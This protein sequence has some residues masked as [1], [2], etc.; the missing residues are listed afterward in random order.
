MDCLFSDIRVGKQGWG[1]GEASERL[2]LF[3]GVLSDCRVTYLRAAGME[4]EV[5][6]GDV[7]AF[8]ISLTSTKCYGRI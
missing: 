6:L 8:L 7:G 3:A 1:C 4:E 5:S 2:A